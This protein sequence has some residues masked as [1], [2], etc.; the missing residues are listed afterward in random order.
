MSERIRLNGAKVVFANLDDTGFGRSITIDAT[1]ADVQKEITDWVK[2]NNIGKGDKAGVPNFKEYEGK[3]QY[4]FK[5]N[6]YTRYAGLNGLTINNLG[7]GARVS[8]IAQAFTYD[9][10]FG[11]GTSASLTAVVVEKAAD[12]AS[13]GD[14]AELLEDA[15]DATPVS[16]DG[17]SGYEKAKEIA[18]RLK[19]KES[20]V[21]DFDDNEEINLSEIPF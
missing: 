12:S 15:P 1:G 14:L 2:E 17:S 9:N 20:V 5:I 18:N 19:N 6:D 21:D 11:K 3:K 8:L 13:D 7:F 16:A 4:A 10:K